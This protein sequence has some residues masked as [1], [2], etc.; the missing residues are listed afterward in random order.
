MSLFRNL[1]GK[2]D[3]VTE[4]GKLYARREWAA[5]LAAARRLERT[6]LP[7]DV[8]AQVAGWETEAGDALAAINLDEGEMAVRLGNHRKGR[9]HF[10]LAAAQ[11]CAPALRERAERLLAEA[12]GDRSA[13]SAAAGCGSSCG[14]TCAPAGGEGPAEEEIDAAGHLELLL[15]TLPHDLA[16]RYVAAGTPFLQA[17]LAAQEGDDALALDLFEQVPAAQRGTLFRAERGVVLARNGR[18]AEAEADLRAALGEFPD[19]FHPFDALV[20]LLAVTGR[21]DDLESLLRRALDEGRFAGY[22]WSRLA[23]LEAGRGHVAAALAAGEQALAEG[24]LDPATVLMCAELQERE[25]NHAK[26]EALFARLPSGGC[27]G[28]AHP[29]LAEFWLRHGQNLDRALESFKGALRHELDNPR[30][31]LRIAQV[32]IAKGW[33]KDAAGPIESLLQRDGLPDELAA[34]IRAA[35]DAIR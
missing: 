9:E 25:G 6:A 20:T 18:S 3:P 16:D 5:L 4:L 27:G 24:E 34:E 1:F 12:G 21:H 33:K 7:A 29:L 23:Q 8:Q 13:P 31:L 28:G 32:Y 14:P 22:C 17:W 11:A 19:L 15:A 26:A 10:Q 30:W 2:S 35:A